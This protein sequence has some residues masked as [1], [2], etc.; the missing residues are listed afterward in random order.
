MISEKFR[1]KL[2]S[3]YGKLEGGVIRSKGLIQVINTETDREMMMHCFDFIDRYMLMNHSTDLW[4]LLDDEVLK[5]YDACIAELQEDIIWSAER[6]NICNA[7]GNAV[8]RGL[9]PVDIFWK[10]FG[11]K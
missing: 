4:L 5:M 7:V 6:S 9:G 11:G 1:E 2:N 8:K 3:R 10:V